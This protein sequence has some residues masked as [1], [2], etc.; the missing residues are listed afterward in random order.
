MSIFTWNFIKKLILFKNI[1]LLEKLMRKN[2]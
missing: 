1:K 2:E